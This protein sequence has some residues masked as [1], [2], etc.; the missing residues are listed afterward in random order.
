VT[1]V[2]FVLGV[3]VALQLIYQAYLAYRTKV[4]S[5]A[6]DLEKLLDSRVERELVRM[7]QEIRYLRARVLA[8]EAVIHKHDIPLPPDVELGTT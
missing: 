5:T 2:E 8:L 4:V 3:V 6:V 1:N 7:E